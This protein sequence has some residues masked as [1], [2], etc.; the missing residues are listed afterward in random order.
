[1]N[2]APS[3]SPIPRPIGILEWST[4][5]VATATSLIFVGSL[6][7][8]CHYGI[9]FSDEGFYLNWISNPWLY[10]TSISQ[11]GFIYHPIYLLAGGN[12][13]LLRQAN[14]LITLGLAWTLCMASFRKSATNE[15]SA[16]TVPACYLYGTALIMSTSS[17]VLFQLWLPTPNY[18][19]L[20]LQSLLLAATGLIMAEANSSR[21]SLAGW[22]LLG[23]GG[24]LAFMAKPSTAGALGLF[25]GAYLIFTRRL[26]LRLLAVSL[27]SAAAL[28]YGSAL[29]MDGSIVGFMWR[30]IDAAEYA[31]HFGGHTFSVS[32]RLDRFTLT[33][34][35]KMVFMT[36][37]L[38]VFLSS[39]SSLSDR[40]PL[41]FLGGTLALVFGVTGGLLCSGFYYAF[42]LKPVPFQMLQSWAVVIGAVT[43]AVVTLRWS[44]FRMISR[45][46]L[47]LTFCFVSFTYA[48]A[49]GTNANYWTV[50]SKAVIFGLL[51]GA[52]ILR[53]ANRTAGSWRS[54]MSMAAGAQLVVIALMCIGL[55]H[56]YRQSEPLRLQ[57]D[58]V[59]VSPTGGELK[60][61]RSAADYIRRL[62]KLAS[63]SGFQR[64]TPVIDLTG[65]YPGALYAIGANAIGQAWMLGGDW[66]AATG[67]DHVSCAELGRAWVLVEP[68]GPRQHNPGILRRFNMDCERDFETAGV[69]DSPIAENQTSFRQKLLKP[70]RLSADAQAACERRRKQ[71]Y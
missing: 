38:L 24:W 58:K 37:A 36:T 4:L 1:M 23:I 47:A 2:K 32:L 33:N 31:S 25:S 45:D 30:L 22:L 41:R 50:E 39:F 57:Q 55:E 44:I 68:T 61:S 14:I 5:A 71:L 26:E 34:S 53:S 66:G 15:E 35:E 63:D 49:F 8:R 3:S 69:L 64:G 48:F 11:F 19:S 16:N 67:L 56:P 9:E 21:R 54:V 51:A 65:H 18:N 27:A 60:V 59:S 10:K 12:L 52:T 42:P 43:A 20:T 13:G 40:K 7:R 28:T 29:V 17:L 6:L 46:S 62:K 70:T